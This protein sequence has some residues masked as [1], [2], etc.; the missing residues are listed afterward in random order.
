MPKKK[1]SEERI[2][3]IKIKKTSHKEEESFWQDLPSEKKEPKL[4]E[5]IKVIEKKLHL[6][7]SKK[8]KEFRSVKKISLSKEK[9]YSLKPLKFSLVVLGTLILSLVIL[10]FSVLRPL[11]TRKYLEEGNKEYN[12]QRFTYA[13]QNYQKA[14]IL[15]PYNS[16]ILLKLSKLYWQKGLYNEANSFAQKALNYNQKNAEIYFI[17][18]ETEIVNQNYSEAEKYLLKAKEIAPNY[19]EIYPPL[20]FAQIALNKKEE[21]QKNNERA[22]LETPENF[23]VIY[24][25]FILE[26]MNHNFDQA[27]EALQKLELLKNYQSEQ[28]IKENLEFIEKIKNQSSESPYFHVLLGNFYLQNNLNSLALESFNKALIINKNYRDAYLGLAEIYLQQKDYS[29]AQINLKKA[30]E[31]DSVYGLTDYLWSRFYADQNN[32]TKAQDYLEQAIIKGYDNFSSRTKLAEIY[33]LKE[34]W[35]KALEQYLKITESQNNLEIWER[36]IWLWSDKMNKQNQALDKA[37]KIVEENPENVLAYN[38]LGEAYLYSN[39]L[40]EAQEAFNQALSID[41]NF[42]LTYYNLGLLYLKKNNSPQAE[43][44]FIKAADLDKK[45]NICNR[46]YQKIKELSN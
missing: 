2:I 18:G 10:F 19:L 23:E 32:W 35:S 21:A 15:N 16:E 38:I 30:E 8:K 24:N 3:P 11:W 28:R 12:L 6:E 40:L 20:A 42:A 45:G 1:K 46:S 39:Q 33:L 7:P 14:L 22:F 31:I 26:V 5:E 25:L 36:I 27:Q 37:K 4:K 17:L 29:K 34:N 9:K 41:N 13:L 43:D 44:N